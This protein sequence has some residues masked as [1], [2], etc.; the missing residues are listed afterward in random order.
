MDGPKALICTAVGK[1]EVQTVTKP[2]PP[3]GHVLVKTKAVALNPTDYK[4]IHE[5]HGSAIGKR[6]GVDFSG[7]IEEVGPEVS[8]PWKKGDR[9]A[10][11]VFGA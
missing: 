1:V 2:T 9:V 6:P 10:G 3:A 5:P 11:G 7:I 4:S 8:R